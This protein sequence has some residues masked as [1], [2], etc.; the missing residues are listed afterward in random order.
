MRFFQV[1]GLS[2]TTV[3]E[4]RRPHKK[5]KF[6]TI[7]GWMDKKGALTLLDE[8]RKA[9]Q[10][11]P[12]GLGEFGRLRSLDTDFAELI[13]AN[14]LLLELGAKLVVPER[15]IRNMHP[16]HLTLRNQSL[17]LL[18]LLVRRWTCSALASFSLIAL[19]LGPLTALVVT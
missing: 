13:Q 6:A 12:D 10:P 16:R 9:Y 2:E 18:F 15:W 19:A 7:K 1:P 3:V 4:G 14:D 5:T 17:L 11:A 8:C